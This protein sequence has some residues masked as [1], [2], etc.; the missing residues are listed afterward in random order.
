[1]RPAKLLNVERDVNWQTDLIFFLIADI[2]QF[3]QC[4]FYLDKVLTQSGKSK[5]LTAYEIEIWVRFYKFLKILQKHFC[6]ESLKK[7]MRIKIRQ[8]IHS[9]AQQISVTSIQLHMIYG[10]F[11]VLF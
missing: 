1:M 7:A 6:R 4:F 5:T 10:P 9:D 3:N 2:S 11:Y 8:K